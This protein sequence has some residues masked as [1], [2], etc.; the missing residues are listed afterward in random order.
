MKDHTSLGLF[1]FVLYGGGGCRASGSKVFREAATYVAKAGTAN[2][3]WDPSTVV[4]S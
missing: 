4:A 2:T 1:V 3:I